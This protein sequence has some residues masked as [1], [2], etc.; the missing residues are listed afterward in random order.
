MT[1]RLRLGIVGSVV[2]LIAATFYWEGSTTKNPWS[3]HRHCI[4]RAPPNA[5]PVTP[6]NACSFATMP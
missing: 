3:M 6:G 1:G 4:G 2:W 5:I